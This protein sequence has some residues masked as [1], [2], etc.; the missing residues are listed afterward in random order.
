LKHWSMPLRHIAQ[1]VELSV[2]KNDMSSP[3]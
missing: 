2:I 1:A 3:K